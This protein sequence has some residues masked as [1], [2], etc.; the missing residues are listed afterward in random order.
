MKKNRVALPEKKIV[1]VFTKEDEDVCKM[2]F[3]LDSIED[4]V[5]FVFINPEY[6]KIGEEFFKN[7]PTAHIVIVDVY[8][9]GQEMK[10]FIQCLRE[11]YPDLFFIATASRNLV[12]AYDLKNSGADCGV[13]KGELSYPFW[14]ARI[15]LALKLKQHFK[16]E[17]LPPLLKYLHKDDRADFRKSA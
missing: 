11:K 7:H 5:I 13:S 17:E 16:R 3:P 4:S 2:F 15:A 6:E 1:L 12:A 8:A 10:I 9:I 14:V